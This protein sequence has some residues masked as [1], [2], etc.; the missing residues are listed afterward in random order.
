MQTAGA[1]LQKLR[2]GSPSM[3]WMHQ[4]NTRTGLRKEGRRGGRLLYLL[5][6][7]E[8]EPEIGHESPNGAIQIGHRDRYVVQTGNHIF[9]AVTL[10]PLIQGEV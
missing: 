5:P 10:V 7:L 3:Q 9:V 1:L 6:A 8:G 4:L 2:Y